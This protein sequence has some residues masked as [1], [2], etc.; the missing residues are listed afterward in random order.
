MGA[1]DREPLVPMDKNFSTTGM[2]AYLV[3]QPLKTGATLSLALN[4]IVREVRYIPARSR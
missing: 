2:I 4:T 1:C 3:G